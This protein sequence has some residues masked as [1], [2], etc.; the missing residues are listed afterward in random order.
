VTPPPR[1]LNQPSDFKASNTTYK[2]P[3]G[4]RFNR[5]FDLEGQY[6]RFGTN[7]HGDNT[8]DANGWT[9]DLHVN[10]PLTEQFVPY[11]KAGALFWNSKRRFPVAGAASQQ[12]EQDGNGTDFTWGA[13]V[14]F[15]FT[16]QLDLRL[17]YERFQFGDVDADNGSGSFEHVDGPKANMGSAA[18]VFNF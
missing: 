18:L 9:S 3:F 12:Q 6:I 16:P 4:F 13:G 7:D 17:E 10:F 8:I 11:A 5:V 1:N 15:R 14:K 2:V